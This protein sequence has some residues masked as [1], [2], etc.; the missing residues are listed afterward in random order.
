MKPSRPKA[1]L[2]DRSTLGDDIAISDLLSLDLDWTIHDNTQPE[3]LTERIKD[4]DIVLSNKVIIHAEHMNQAPSL[5][6]IGI[7]A[8]GTNNIDIPA[9]SARGIAVTNITAYG[10]PGVAQHT[11]AMMLSLATQLP[12]YSR[13]SIDG[14]WSNSNTFCVMDAPVMELQGKTLLVVGYGELGKA[15]AKLAEAFGMNILIA[16]VPGSRSESRGRISLEEGLAQADVVSLHCPLTEQTRNMIDK[17][18]LALMK[19]HALLLNTARGGLV[20]EQALADA[21][22]QKQIGGA[23]FD[24]LTEEPPANGNPLLELDIPNLTI[25]PHTAWLAKESRSRMVTIAAE[26]IQV[27]LNGERQRRVD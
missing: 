24:V 26:N 12:R 17:H 27:F 7:L 15:V 21:L 2:L 4:A 5:K 20:N 8:T 9:A 19:P 3:Q 23:G 1:V 10:T 16:Q 18:Q 14:T 13:L 6:Y 25:T 22:K 11:M